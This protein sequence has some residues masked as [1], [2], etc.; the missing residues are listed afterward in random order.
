MW[1]QRVVVENYGG[2]GGIV[3]MG[4][5]V[6]SANDGYTF[7]FIPGS[8]SMVTPVLYKEPGFNVEKDLVP[9]ATVGEVPYLIAVKSH[10]R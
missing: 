2:A 5:L 1:S 3:G 10:P 7:G 8:I 6:R 9:V 4:K